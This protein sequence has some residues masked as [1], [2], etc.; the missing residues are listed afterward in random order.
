MI[1]VSRWIQTVRPG[2]WAELEELE[3]KYQDVER[4]L[5]FPP[6]KKRYRS[7]AGGHD[8]STLIVEFHWDSL[9]TMEVTLDRLKAA[10]E[11]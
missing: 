3:K 11:G 2:K 4:R 9:A 1:V 6:T 10:L 5:G 8:L 7:F